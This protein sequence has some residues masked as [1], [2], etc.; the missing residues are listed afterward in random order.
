MVAQIIPDSFEAKLIVQTL[1]SLNLALPNYLGRG[2]DAVSQ[3]FASPLEMRK[4]Q[5]PA[6]WALMVLA[7]TNSLIL[8]DPLDGWNL[9]KGTKYLHL[10][11]QETG[12]RVRVLKCDSYT[13]GLTHAGRN[14]SRRALYYQ[15]AAIRSEEELDHALNGPS[16]DD[17][18]IFVTWEEAAEG[19]PLLTGYKPLE[20]GR[21]RQGAKASLVVSLGIK[22]EDYDGLSF[23]VETREPLF[24][25]A[26]IMS[27]EEL[28]EKEK[29]EKIRIE[30]INDDEVH[31]T[32]D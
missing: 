1:S 14:R 12:L 10:A 9:E 15:P 27:E 18:T 5:Y 2:I 23:P 22:Q 20:P 29:L 3:A 13:G 19:G 32:K 4:E 11:H 30:G 31:S 16:L 17:V 26:G 25:P 28:E 7:K 24:F 8:K 21:W 6:Q